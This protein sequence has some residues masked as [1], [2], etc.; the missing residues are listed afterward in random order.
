MW[1]VCGTAFIDCYC[2]LT[3][4]S[5]LFL[6][7][8]GFKGVDGLGS[9]GVCSKARVGFKERKDSCHLQRP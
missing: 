1:D 5:I 9:V 3:V 2:A 6:Q 4:A 7:V 8:S